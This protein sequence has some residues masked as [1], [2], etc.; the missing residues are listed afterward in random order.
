MGHSAESGRCRRW[1]KL[2]PRRRQGS[3]L[4]AASERVESLGQ[5]C[6]GRFLEFCYL[7]G[8]LE[9]LW[10]SPSS[11][12]SGSGLGWQ[13]LR[14]LRGGF[15][16]LRDNGRRRGV[17]CSLYP[18]PRMLAQNRDKNDGAKC[19]GQR[20]PAEYWPDAPAASHRRSGGLGRLGFGRQRQ[21]RNLPAFR[22]LGEMAQNLR[23]LAL[24]QRLFQES[25]EEVGVR[26]L[27][28]PI[29]DCRL[30]I[31]LTGD[32]SSFQP[33]QHDS[34]YSPHNWSSLR[35]PSR[36]Q[37]IGDREQT[38]KPPCFHPSYRTLNSPPSC[39]F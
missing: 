37:G 9:G 32:G 35:H 38:A 31:V 18:V 16:R 29:F 19:R 6:W 27:E 23:P 28:W 21:G 7:A 2:C 10:L 12:C 34:W 14:S 30:S 15:A 36:E 1:A 3:S 26:M 33:L 22:T 25:C 8:R 39:G 11:G 13:G 17:R 20:A 24:R 4:N 5:W